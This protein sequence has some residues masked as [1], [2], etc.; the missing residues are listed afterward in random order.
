ME[1]M[2]KCCNCNETK[3]IDKFGKDKSIKSGYTYDCKDCRNA[4]S[5]KWSKQNKEK[6]KHNNDRN[7]EKRKN[8]HNTLTGHQ[9]WRNHHLTSN[10]NITNDDYNKLLESQNGVCGICGKTESEVSKR[11]TYLCVD[12][13]HD[14]NKVRGLLCS[15]CNRGIGLLQDDI[16]ILKKGIEYLT[17]K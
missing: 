4:K 1:D 12:H 7:K 15:K 2:K 3:T 14:T 9:R 11:N 8:T 13:D 10:Y 6:R 17:K 5:R 16:N